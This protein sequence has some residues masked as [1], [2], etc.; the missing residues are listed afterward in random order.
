MLGAAQAGR[1]SSLRLLRLLRDEELIA[2]AREE[3]SAVVSADPTLAGHHA[4]A[5]AI[6]EILGEDRAEY[7][8]KS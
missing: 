5:D 7:L 6:G 4:L 1:H 8:D 3:A 2:A